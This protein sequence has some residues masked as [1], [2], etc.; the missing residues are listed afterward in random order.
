MDVLIHS[1]DRDAIQLVNDQVTLLY[2]K[3]G[4]SLL[5][6]FTPRG[7]RGEGPAA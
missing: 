2:P 1:G 4:E 6:R 3:R 7:G 5:T